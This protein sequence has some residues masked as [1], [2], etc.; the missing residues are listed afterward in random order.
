MQDVLTNNVDPWV[1]M[2]REEALVESL[3]NVR[4]NGS[5]KFN[6]SLCSPKVRL[7]ASVDLEAALCII[8]VLAK[9]KTCLVKSNFNEKYNNASYER[10]DF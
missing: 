1:M 4:F 2:R 8:M 7:R 10:P 5:L 3:R 9:F 6:C